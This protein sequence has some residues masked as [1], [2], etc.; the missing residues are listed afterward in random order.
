MRVLGIDSATWTASAGIV[1]DGKVVA[2]CSVAVAGN[3]A[4]SILPLVEEALC[5][6]AS[7]LDEIDLLSVSIG[8]GSFTGLRVGLSIAKG[9]SL[10]SGIPVIGVPTLEA[11]ALAAG[12]REGSVCPVLDA[13][14]GEV[15]A[16]SYAWLADGLVPGLSVRTVAPEHLLEDL[17]MPC[18][19][20]GDGVDAY[21]HI[22]EK[23]ISGRGKLLDAACVPPTGAAVASLGASYVRRRGPD[24]LDSLGPA[25][26]RPSAAEVQRQRVRSGMAGKLTESGLLS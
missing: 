17:E 13:R 12:R 22:W 20:L 18:T 24:D 11:L 25:Y 10:S 14:K 16:A 19:L 23:G 7:R 5:A 21:R 26:V 4:Q 6:A 15:Y 1:D 3:H 2:L 9:I 8:P